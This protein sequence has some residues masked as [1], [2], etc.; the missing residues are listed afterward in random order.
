MQQKNKEH[1]STTKFHFSLWYFS[2]S[3]RTVYSHLISRKA[4]V[5][6]PRYNRRVAGRFREG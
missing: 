4:E 5:K 6:K 3:Q 2:E 1:I